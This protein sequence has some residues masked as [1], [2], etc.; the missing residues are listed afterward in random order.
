MKVGKGLF[1]HG[2]DRTKEM[3]WRNE[4]LR[5]TV[6]EHPVGLEVRSAHKSISLISKGFYAGFYHGDRIYVT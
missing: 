5:G 4:G 6:A 1:D 2:A 3:I